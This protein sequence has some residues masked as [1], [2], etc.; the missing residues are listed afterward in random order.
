MSIARTDGPGREVHH[1]DALAWLRERGTLPGAS[2]V[3]SLPDVSELR[4]LSLDEW[5]RWYVDA[6]ALVMASVSDDGAAIFYQTD[7]QREGVWIDKSALVADA[8]AR[9]GAVLRFHKIVC[10]VPAGTIR[11]GRAGYAH[12]LCYGGPAPSPRTDT[13]DVLEDGGSA[14]SEKSM[15]T[16]ACAMACRYVLAETST[17]TIVDPFCGWGTTLA[18][19][20]AL[21]LAAVGVDRS[22]RMCRR[23]RAL[24]LEWNSAAAPAALPARRKARR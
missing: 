11:H 12:L 6:A 5:R 21:G 14:L 18:V 24:H 20:N 23:A 10:R 16:E 3:T 17:R 19:A 22:A 15:G 9:A 13:A 7:I 8:A 1:A 2:V 4:G